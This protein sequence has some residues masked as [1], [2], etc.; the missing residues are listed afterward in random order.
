MIRDYLA[1]ERVGGRIKAEADIDSI[2]MNL[3]GGGQL[4]YESGP[5]NTAE[6][7]RLVAAA[8]VGSQTDRRPRRR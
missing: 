6:V 8:L 1:A 5:P 4:L 3:I 2:G 7:R